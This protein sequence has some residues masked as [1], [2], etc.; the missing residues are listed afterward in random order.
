MEHVLGD[1]SIE[2]GRV[3]LLT[4]TGSLPLTAAEIYSLVTHGRSAR[5]ELRLPAAETLPDIA[6]MSRPLTVFIWVRNTGE[7]ALKIDAAVTVRGQ[8]EVLR[9]LVDDHVLFGDMWYPLDAE[10][11]GAAKECL[12]RGASEETPLATYTNIYR[13]LNPFCSNTRRCRHRSVAEIWLLQ[14]GP[15]DV[16]RQIFTHTRKRVT[17]GFRKPSR[18]VLVASL[19]M[20]WA[21]ARQSRSLR[22]W[23]SVAVGGWGP[24][25]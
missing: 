15:F 4:D 14:A 22:C 21:S 25:L 10:S 23:R 16:F 2:G 9:E 13:G 19:P 1:L 5:L 12:Q 18:Q 6:F 20:R 3:V 24:R 8:T 11:L 7:A 17:N